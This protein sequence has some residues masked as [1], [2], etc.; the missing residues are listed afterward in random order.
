MRRTSEYRRRE[1]EASA[2]AKTIRQVA[3]ARLFDGRNMNVFLN[4][5]LRETAYDVT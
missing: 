4:Q 1:Q 2:L 5:S 3:L